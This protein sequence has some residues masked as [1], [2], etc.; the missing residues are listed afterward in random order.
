MHSILA[1]QMWLF[2]RI[3]PLIVGDL[4]PDDDE[5]WSNYLRLMEIVDLLFCPQVSEDC[6]EYL[7]ALISDRHETF[8]DLYPNNNVIPKMHFM[9][10]MPR[11]TIR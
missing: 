9:V 2:G 1:A 8:V 6:A 7:A 3:L 10:H 11:L 5:R 4:V